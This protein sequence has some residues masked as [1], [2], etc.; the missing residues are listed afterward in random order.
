MSYYADDCCY[1]SMLNPDAKLLEKI[2]YAK[3]LYDEQVEKVKKEQYILGALHQ[4]VVDRVRE[5]KSRYDYLEIYRKAQEEIG[6]RY[7]KDRRHFETVQSFLR[8]DF[9]N[10]DKKFKLKK[11]ISCG[12]EDYAWRFEFEGYGK[13]ID[14]SV[15][16][17]RN[18]TTKNVQYAHYGMFTFSVEET[19]HV[20]KMLKGSYEMSEIAQTIKDYVK[21]W[22]SEKEASCEWYVY[23]KRRVR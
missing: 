13:T 23:Q 7:K 1:D 2:R 11:I 16:Y 9:L 21:S 6:N 8:E 19:E 22:T 15:P 4:D 14:I 5:R 10:N 20:W 12:F 17:M 18:I 3:E